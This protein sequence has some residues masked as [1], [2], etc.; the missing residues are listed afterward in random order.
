MHPVSY[1]QISDVQPSN[2]SRH[3][4]LV[5]VDSTVFCGQIRGRHQLPSW[6]DQA[7]RERTETD[8]AW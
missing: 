6:V 2:L 5:G 8:P 1:V 7:T 4:T 3:V